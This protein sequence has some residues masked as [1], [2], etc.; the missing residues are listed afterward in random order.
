M[1]SVFSVKLPLLVVGPSRLTVSESMSGSETLTEDISIEFISVLPLP[2]VAVG[3]ALP[4]V[5]V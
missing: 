2:F 5:I 1:P 3:A 4:T